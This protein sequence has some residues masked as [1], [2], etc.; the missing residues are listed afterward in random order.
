MQLS[1]AGLGFGRVSLILITHL[2]G[3]HYFGLPGLL[4]TLASNG[5]TAPLT[6]ISPPGLEELLA[7]LLYAGGW[8]LPYSLK[9]VAH[10]AVAFGSLEQAVN[11]EALGIKD[12]EVFSFPLRHRI[13]CNGYLI[14]ERQRLPN[15][16]KDQIEA[17]DIPWQQMERIKAGHD[18]VT[19]DGQRIP[20]SDLTVPAAPPR[21]YAY[22]S[23]THYFSELTEYVKGVDL[24]YHEAT[25]LHD[26]ADK[27]RERGHATAHEAA[28]IAAAAGVGQLVMGHF[29]AKYGDLAPFEAEARRVFPRSYV[30]RDLYRFSVPYVPAT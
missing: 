26:E 16:R 15:L 12:L 21:S 19:R 25:Y 1:A 23:D 28:R 29:S 13:L 9:F 7:P 17:Y 10:T 14:R 30:A 3:D 27:A 20:A 2:H 5:R 6:I 22:C 11:V 4:T 18:F 8:Q 24:L